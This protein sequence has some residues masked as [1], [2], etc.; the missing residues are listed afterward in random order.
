MTCL[1][2]PLPGLSDFHPWPHIPPTSEAQGTHQGPGP[3]PASENHLCVSEASPQSR[4][5]LLGPDRSQDRVTACLP[6]P[7]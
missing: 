5:L 4:Y 3:A 7:R 2:D 6:V 1:M